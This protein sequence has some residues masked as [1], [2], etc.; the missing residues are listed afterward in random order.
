VG[1]G[2]RKKVALVCAGGGVTGAVYEIGCLTALEDLLDRSILDLDLYVGVSGGAFVAS[3]L[4]CG[5]S[6]REMY[7]QA[8]SRGRRPL[9]AF[10]APLFRLGLGEFLKRSLQT[11]RVLGEALLMALGGEGRNLADLG[12]ALFELLP[13]GLLENSGVQEYLSEIYR[14]RG[15]KDRF[16]ALPRELFVV[17]VDLDNG[18]AVTFGGKGLRDVS[19]SKAVQASS[20][21]P[22]LY[23]PV[24]IRGRDY[25]DGG[26][27]KTAHINLAI[28]EGADLIICLNPIVP[29][30]T[31]SRG[32]LNGHLSNKGVAY[33]LDQAL[34]IM[35]HGRMQ[36][37]LER[38][39]AEH[40]KVD[41]LLIEPS[42]DDMRMFGYNIMRYSARQVV[43]RDGY[44]NVLASFERNRKAYKRLLGRHGIAMKDPFPLPDE[45]P[46]SDLS[47]ALSGSLELLESKLSIPRGRRRPSPSRPRSWRGSG[48]EGRTRGGPHEAELRGNPRTG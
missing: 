16:D 33:V 11:P 9:G 1:A 7:E 19:V 46:H 48:V 37:G 15:C 6:P 28:R 22:G 3:L 47:R 24:R 25:V 5:V 29:I 42:R 26:V 38:Y 14:S 44:R 32:P 18:E 23:R 31:R 27:K 30:L 41:I 21:L 36:Y 12:F 10:Q 8:T 17:A 43:A 39:Q 13:A 2:R 40:P 35:L 45:G 4:A 20:A 34:R